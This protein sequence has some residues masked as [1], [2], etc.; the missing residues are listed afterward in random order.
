MNN[1]LVVKSNIEVHG[2]ADEVMDFFLFNKDYTPSVGDIFWFSLSPMGECPFVI[3]ELKDNKV[4]FDSM[5]TMPFYVNYV[6]IEVFESMIYWYFDDAVRDIMVYTD[7][8]HI[9]LS[10][11]TLGRSTFVFVPAASEI[12]SGCECHGDKNIYTQLDWYKN[13]M[14]RIIHPFDDDEDDELNCYL[15]SS[16]YT[17]EVSIPDSPDC[18]SQAFCCVVDEN[19]NDNFSPIGT[20]DCNSNSK[21]APIAFYLER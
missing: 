11:R 1:D 9:G 7:R 6:G 16:I 13:R 3:T 18:D 15:T 2:S 4:R 10:G 8:P 5:V 19:G 12:F 17:D 21:Y 20:V 14:H